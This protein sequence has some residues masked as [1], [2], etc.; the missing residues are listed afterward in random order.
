MGHLLPF[1]GLV[2]KYSLFNN[3]MKKWY[4]NS[5]TWNML[6]SL[7]SLCLSC[8]CFNPVLFF[9]KSDSTIAHDDG[10][11]KDQGS[12]VLVTLY[13]KHLSHRD[14]RNSLMIAVENDMNFVL[15]SSLG[16]WK[17]KWLLFTKQR[18]RCFHI[19]ISSLHIPKHFKLFLVPLL[20][21][22]LNTVRLSL[23]VCWQ[24]LIELFW[25]QTC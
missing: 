7:L 2:S 22:I 12:M 23:Q 19:T 3:W 24:I 21:F 11:I 18:A 25:E 13:C 9:L 16:T 5:I 14:E 17:S 10:E 20:S 1:R 8:W 4:N 6:S 15:L